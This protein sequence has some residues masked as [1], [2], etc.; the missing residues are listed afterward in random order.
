MGYEAN[1]PEKIKNNK[2]LYLTARIGHNVFAIKSDIVTE[3]MEKPVIYR[4]PRMP[5]MVLG[6]ANVRDMVIPVYDMR[7]ALGMKLFETEREEMTATM[8]QREEDHKK[9]LIELE[10][11]VREKREFTL[12]TDPHKCKFGI[13]Y[14][15][16][17][18]DDFDLAKLLR[19]FDEP[20]KMIHSLAVKAKEL[21]DD[22]RQDAAIDLIDGTGKSTLGKMITLFDRACGIMRHLD[23]R[24]LVI[25]RT[26]GKMKGII[27][28]SAESAVTIDQSM[29]KEEAIY[30]DE[31]H[32][33]A[34][35]ETGVAEMLEPESL[36]H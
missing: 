17:K 27:V 21:M 4:I 16:F 7:S 14:D 22:G 15:S 23:R 30:G 9:W 12:Q 11:C 2:N 18:T 29:I 13:W 25:V 26:E 8:R 19:E 10:K 24:I 28:D 20:H 33:F 3:L 6:A 36:L 32:K 31:L 35:L 1:P 34:R 5:E